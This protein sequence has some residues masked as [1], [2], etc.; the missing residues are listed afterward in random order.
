MQFRLV[1]YYLLI[2]P[3]IFTT[4]SNNLHLFNVGLFLLEEEKKSEKA[5]EKKLWDYLTV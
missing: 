4:V 2:I 5:S 1:V 3:K